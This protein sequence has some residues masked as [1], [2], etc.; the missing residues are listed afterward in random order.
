M[1]DLVV[2][3]KGCLEEKTLVAHSDVYNGNVFCI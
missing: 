1:W 2:K 3:D